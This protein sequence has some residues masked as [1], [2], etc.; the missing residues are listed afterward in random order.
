MSCLTI[1]RR[2]LVKRNCPKSNWLRPDS[3]ES[4]SSKTNSKSLFY[5]IFTLLYKCS[6]VLSKKNNL[7]KNLN[8]YI[9]G[10]KM[11]I[12]IEEEEQSRYLDTFNQT[13]IE[14]TYYMDKW[15]RFPVTVSQYFGNNQYEFK[16]NN[17]IILFLLKEC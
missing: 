2:S 9:E 14:I 10:Y 6:A 11:M 12:H 17:N 5:E 7:R 15:F 1:S 16:T 8:D 4:I 3:G 13:D